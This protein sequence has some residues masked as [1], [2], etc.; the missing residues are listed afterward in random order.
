M[1]T[2][3]MGEI[4][5][6]LAITALAGMLIGWCIKSLFTD[7]TERK[8]REFVAQDVDN[9]T[10]DVKLIQATLDKK[11]AELRDATVE[12]QQ[13]RGRDVSLKAGNSTQIQ[14][15]NAL[16]TELAESR[17]TLERNRAEFNA[18]RNEKQT[19]TLTLTNKL[20][21]FQAG[22]PVYDERIKEANETIT[23][24]RTAVQE[25]D[26]IIDSLRARVKEGDQSVESLR[27]QLKTVESAARDVQSAEDE[28]KA[29][30]ISLSNQLREIS[31]QR[32]NFKR[33]FE[34]STESKNAEIA[35]HQDRLEELANVRNLLSRKEQDYNK[36]NQESRELSARSGA[37]I[38]EL[39]RA[40]ADRDSTQAQTQKELKQLLD[41]I[42]TLKTDNKNVIASQ[43]KQL[44]SLQNQLDTASANLKAATA[45]LGQKRVARQEIET[46]NAEVAALNDLLR[47]VSGKRD[48]LQNRITDFEK[49]LEIAAK[50]AENA[51]DLQ[52]QLQELEATVATRD[53]Q[54]AKLK[55]EMVDVSAKRRRLEADVGEL[56]SA[57]NKIQ[58]TLTAEAASKLTALNGRLL[59]TEK[60]TA[61]LRSDLKQREDLVSKLQGEIDELVSN[62]DALAEELDE[63]KSASAKQAQTATTEAES[64]LS[65][66]NA[67][68]R[69]RD[70]KI[71][72]LRTAM[73]EMTSSRDQLASMV[74][75]L[76]GRAEQLE[77]FKSEM[78]QT[79]T[80]RSAELQQR[81]VAYAKL[82]S[83]FQNLTVTRDDYETRL[84]QLRARVDEQSHTSEAEI[85][86]LK[87]QVADLRSQ[88]SLAQSE[89]Q[90]LSEE[91]SGTEEL[92]LKITERESEIQKLQINSRDAVAASSLDTALEEHAKKNATLTSVLQERDAE[93]GRL[94]AIITDNRVGSKQHTSEISL[95]KQEVE[96]QSTLIQSL[97]EQ[98]ENT[99]VLHKKIASQSTEIEELRAS[100]YEVQ[101]NNSVTT[102]TGAPAANSSVDERL[103]QLQQ[104]LNVKEIDLQ[105]LKNQAEGAKELQ[106]QN[107]E[108]KRAITARNRELQQTRLELASVAATTGRDTATTNTDASDAGAAAS[109]HTEVSTRAAK[110]K[111]RVFVRPGATASELAGT[112]LIK[113]SRAQYTRDGYKLT[114][115][116]GTDD[117]TLLPGIDKNSAYALSQNGIAEFEQ[118]ALWERREVAHFAERANVPAALAESYDWPGC[119]RQILNGSYRRDKK[120][121]TLGT[122]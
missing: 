37:Q 6:V 69:E 25:N 60:T 11:E 49:Q 88:L 61:T 53:T 8:V 16:K 33:D 58:R 114:S 24:L 101:H 3:V 18:F 77:S 12:L 2:Y 62:R 50:N 118:I 95:L 92:K 119:A 52:K 15:I 39:K 47:D 67:E 9:A 46:K 79:V 54:I 90:H 116:D 117:L 26:K 87:A 34:Q 42:K 91:L 5:T 82:Q 48:S 20:A 99:L 65:A 110:T 74:S 96:S 81:S 31:I 83:E 32:D 97:E 103:L 57:G 75:E 89:N 98:A 109:A 28:R 115:A 78:Q 44:A 107:E 13:L 4:A 111:P 27:M 84:N 120:M 121:E 38:T 68:M 104:Q 7:R 56:K 1:N 10:A 51:S 100:L 59:E 41:Q 30:I 122:A 105:R 113:P 21:G 29:E 63:L 64:K 43:E 35:N 86:R 73:S 72:K 22:G 14:E 102:S 76:K 23:A 85:A 71:E 36:L 40:V 19:E 70:N 45:E 94:N 106:S 55:S 108:L 93:I 17:Q 112:E 80:D 66:L